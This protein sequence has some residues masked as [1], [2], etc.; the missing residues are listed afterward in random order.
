ML[1]LRLEERLHGP[2]VR[3]RYELDAKLLPDGYL[4]GELRKEAWHVAEID[5]LRARWSARLGHFVHVRL[6]DAP[7]TDLE[8]LQDALWR[9]QQFVPGDSLEASQAELDS[10]MRIITL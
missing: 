4:A 8:W 2:A 9:A 6:V 7:V 3:E 1:I 10:L 5:R